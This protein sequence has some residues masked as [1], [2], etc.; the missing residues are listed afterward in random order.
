MNIEILIEGNN[1]CSSVFIKKQKSTYELRFLESSFAGNPKAL[2]FD[3]YIDLK[4][5]YAL[6]M[7]IILNKADAYVLNLGDLGNETSSKKMAYQE[8]LR[9]IMKRVEYFIYGEIFL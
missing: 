1:F 2:R 6:S 7:D 8:L 3:G 9:K 4:K 5:D